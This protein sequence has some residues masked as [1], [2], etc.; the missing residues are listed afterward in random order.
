MPHPF[1]SIQISVD[2]REF[3]SE[4]TETFEM[5]C[6]HSRM[7]ISWTAKKTSGKVLHDEKREQVDH[8]NQEVQRWSTKIIKCRPLKHAH[9]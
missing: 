1:N 3:E 9:D 6:N 8:N 4:N 5:W 7:K 2:K